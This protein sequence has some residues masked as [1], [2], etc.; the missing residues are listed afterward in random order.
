VF[1]IIDDQYLF[2]RH[3]TSLSRFGVTVFHFSIHTILV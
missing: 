2:L 3:E 1:V